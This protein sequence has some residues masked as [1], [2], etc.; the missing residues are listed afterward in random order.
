MLPLDIQISDDLFV[1][2]GVYTFMRK[3]IVLLLHSIILR[4]H[5]KIGSERT[6][7][8][9]YHILQGK[10]SIQTLQDVRLFHL[11][12]YFRIYP[13]LKKEAY[14]MC[15]ASLEKEGLLTCDEQ[16]SANTNPDLF[17]LSNDFYLN[18]VQ[19]KQIDE[20]FYGRLLLLI[21]VWTNSRENNYKFIPIIENEAVEQWVKGY[22]YETKAFINQYLRKLYEE[23]SSALQKVK[24]EYAALFVDLLTA[25]QHI[26]LTKEQLTLK[27]ALSI[28]DVYLIERHVLHVLMQAGLEEKE[29]FPLLNR[30]LSGLESPIKLTESAKRTYRLLQGGESME[31][32]ARL[33]RLKTNTIHD[34]VVEIALEDAMFSIRDYVSVIDEAAIINAVKDLDSYRLK[35]IKSAVDEEITYFQIRLVLTR[36]RE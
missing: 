10:T 22:F 18:G 1:L 2:V 16:N 34:H 11:E 26:G 29:K 24:N 33:R 14:D 5:T 7:N 13:T 6:L 17:A 19:F 32:I 23:L 25:Y 27:Y 28:H 9:I 4:C 35:A 3:V 30:L 15:I 21:Q 36:I 20:V 8:S 12:P 31:A